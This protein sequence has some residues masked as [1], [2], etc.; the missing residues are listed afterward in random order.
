MAE[1][2]LKTIFQLSCQ[3]EHF[4][5]VES[6]PKIKNLRA[7]TDYES[8][9]N[10]L[11]LN[12]NVAQPSTIKDKLG[13]LCLNKPYDEIIFTQAVKYWTWVSSA[14]QLNVNGIFVCNNT[15]G[16]WK[17][18]DDNGTEGKHAQLSK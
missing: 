5:K 7:F 12:K 15:E 6:L 10:Q 17:E 9:H 16:K 11:K 1:M 13:I 4:Y 8:H 14:T 2:S 3:E 18:Q